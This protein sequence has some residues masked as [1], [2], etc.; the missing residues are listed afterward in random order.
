M[1]ATASN[2]INEDFQIILLN[3]EHRQ[4]TKLNYEADQDLKLTSNCPAVHCIP[5]VFAS[6]AVLELNRR[7]LQVQ[8]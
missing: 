2:T 6:A 8:K 4:L 3:K 5:S 1:M 7:E